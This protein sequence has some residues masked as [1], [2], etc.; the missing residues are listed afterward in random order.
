MNNNK[1]IIKIHRSSS[2]IFS[3][4]TNPQ[5]TP[6]WIDSIVAEETSEWPVKLGTIYKNRGADCAW[7]EYEITSWEPNKSF[8]LSERGGTYHVRYTFTPFVDSSTDVE[9]YEW[10]DKGDLPEPYTIDVLQKLKTV[11]EKPYTNIA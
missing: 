11:L 10:V 5:N 8:V 7:S 4:L 6:L 2:D 3:F 1:L 9:Y